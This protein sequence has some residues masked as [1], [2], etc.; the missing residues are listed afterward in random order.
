MPN[1]Y[2]IIIFVAVLAFFG[3]ILFSGRKL[4]EYAVFGTDGE[5]LHLWRRRQNMWLEWSGD[6]V[7]Y[8]KPDASSMTIVQKHWIKRYKEL[9]TGEWVELEKQLKAEMGQ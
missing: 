6:M 5:V 1:V 3:V 7:F 9:R 4:K 8:D 2:G